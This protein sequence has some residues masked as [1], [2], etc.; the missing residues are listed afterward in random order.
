MSRLRIVALAVAALSVMVTGTAQGAE[1]EGGTV[2]KSKKAIK[3]TGTFVL[4]QPSPLGDCIGGS[5]DPT[6]DYFKLKVNMPDGAR[7]KITIPAPS[8]VTDLDLYVYSP[9]GALIG[10][11]G[12]FPGE[13]EV[14]EFR[15]SARFRNK[16]YEIRVLPYLVVPGTTYT[17]TAS[18]K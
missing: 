5:E 3:W 1:P 15:H 6:C 14:V 9:A 4:S 16:E 2:S 18:V 8:A 7:V 11:S 13:G 10:S 17:G 12:N